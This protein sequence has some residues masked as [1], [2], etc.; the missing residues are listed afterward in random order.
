MTYKDDST[1]E[2]FRRRGF[3]QVIAL[4]PRE[5]L[6][7][8]ESAAGLETLQANLASRAGHLIERHGLFDVVI[9]RHVL[10]HAHHLASFL[11]AITQLA[12]PH[13]Y[14]VLEVPDCTTMFE[15]AD[16]SFLWEEHVCYFTPHTF[17]QTLRRHGLHC[18]HLLN[19]PY[20]LENSL[21]AIARPSTRDV[22]A[23]ECSPED[24][25]ERERGEQ[26]AARFPEVRS[27]WHFS[28]ER[29]RRF[30]PITLFGIGH[31][32]V[33]FVNLFGLTGRIDV[34]CDDSPE[35]V[36]RFIPG[37]TLQISPSKVLLDRPIGVC[38]MAVAPESEKRVMAAHS[39]FT[40][41]GG[42]FASIFSAS[43]HA[44]RHDAISAWEKDMA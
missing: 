21:V 11:H 38:L 19:Y 39:E 43:P 30:F 22:S 41:R 37:T 36:D 2:R 27:H 17:M 42:R 15:V 33:T 24:R 6:G 5:D 34:A 40:S 29:L 13:G 20:T 4:D 8:T 1:L 31:L 16:F 25:V 14:V 44:L 3:D 32:A 18:E 28:L 10:E 12:A 9:V 23:V 7:A 35:K 26:F